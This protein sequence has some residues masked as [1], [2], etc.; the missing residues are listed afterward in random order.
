ML[1]RF[2][3][4]L[5]L[6]LAATVC[7]A[8]EA[9]PDCHVGLYRLADGRA[10]DVG[11]SDPGTLRWRL[12]DGTTG[13][14][15]LAGPQAGASK[16]GWTDRLDGRRVEAGDCAGG[17]LTF[18]GQAAHRVALQARETRFTSDGTELAGRLVMPP[19]DGPVPVVVLL[20]GA[21][22]SSAR[23]FDSLQRRLPGEGIGA[24][25]FDKRGTGESGGTYTQDF[26]QLA[27]DAVAA[28]AQARR[29][30]GKRVGRIGFQGPSQGGWVAPIAA[31]HA[32]VD[33][34]I[35]CFGLAVSV[36]EEDRESVALDIANKGW[37]PAVM[38]KAMVLVDAVDALALHP[39]PATFER[40]A[41]VRD[42]VRSEPW[43]KDV[44]GD[45]AWALL[46]LD[47]KQADDAAKTFDWHTPF[48]YDPLETIDRVAAPQLWIQARDDLEAPYAETARRL[49]L[50][51]MAGRPIASA[52]YPHAEHGILEYETAPDGTRT[53]TRQ[54]DGYLALMVDFARGAPPRKSYGTAEIAWP[55]Q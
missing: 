22:H 9:P 16:L 41:D 53:D 24:F 17:E 36:L 6:S 29:L 14:F 45:F 33:F 4:A 43:F 15:A 40:F 52:A 25:V 47:R 49:A 11:A 39:S 42:K 54:P 35:V 38:A 50:L 32:P 19:G 26:E 27:R 7:A 3:T 13:V 31:T 2:A 28:L 8:A 1:D 44:H 10:L 34:V 5:V 18:D 55:S 20:Q 30:G 12:P 23:A 46:G 48:L 37:P 51:R 21:E